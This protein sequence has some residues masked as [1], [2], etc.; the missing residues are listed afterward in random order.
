MAEDRDN[1][2]YGNDVFISYAHLDAE[3]PATNAKEIGEWLESLGYKV[4]WDREMVAGNNIPEVLIPKVIA[5]RHVLVLWSKSADESDWVRT[6]TD[7]ALGL[8]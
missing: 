7:M 2:K 6:E 8:E 5:S 1:S 4:W 3:H